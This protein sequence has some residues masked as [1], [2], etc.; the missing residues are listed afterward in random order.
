MT[1]GIML[2]GKVRRGREEACS[3]G[4][5][6]EGTLAGSV[7]DAGP[8]VS[9]EEVLSMQQLSENIACNRRRAMNNV[10]WP[11]TIC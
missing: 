7:T 6:A 11:T 9:C 3:P 10:W 1:L 4:A 5:G 2:T 8:N